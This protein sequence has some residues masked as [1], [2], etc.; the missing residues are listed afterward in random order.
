MT[1]AR[2]ILRKNSQQYPHCTR[3]EPRN[4]LWTANANRNKLQ[5]RHRPFFSLLFTVNFYCNK[6]GYKQP[7][8]I[9]HRHSLSTSLEM[10]LSKKTRTEKKYIHCHHVTEQ[11]KHA[12]NSLNLFSR[13]SKLIQA[14]QRRMR[15]TER[16]VDVVVGGGGG[17]LNRLKQF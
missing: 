4:V 8:T 2:R 7:V 15:R 9:I 12:L 6:S 14:N 16:V 13:H 11:R 10:I 17:D 1:N 5:N 3:I